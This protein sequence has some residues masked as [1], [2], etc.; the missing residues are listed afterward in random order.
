MSPS[1]RLSNEELVQT[2]LRSDPAAYRVAQE[3]Q[4]AHFRDLYQGAS[5]ALRDELGLAVENHGDSVLFAASGVPHL[6]F[7]R[8][9]RLGAGGSVSLEEVDSALASFARRGVERFIV[10]VEPAASNAATRKLLAQRRLV[11]F[12]RPWVK[13]MR[14]P[15]P[16]KAID[17]DFEIAELTRSDADLFARLL[18]DV[19]GFPHAG[20][21]PYAQAV[22][23]AGHRCYL[24]REQG[25]PAAA[26]AM[27]IEGQ[28]AY[29]A[30]AVT[31]PA[32]RRR[33]AQRALMQRRIS[34]AV[35]AGCTQLAIET[36]FPIA[37]EENP[38]YRNMLHMGF[39]A[40]GKRDN[41]TLEG[42]T[43]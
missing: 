5:E 33:S 16:A 43:W 41:Y 1:A 7:N 6:M 25:K 24:A 35:A 29:F 14:G 9:E 12:R 28:A 40:V 13:L 2:A 39:V 30:G 21:K 26:A 32:F 17:S 15:E 31:L 11:P 18:T 20:G 8:L 10:Q 38:S 4:E 27:Y 19:F 42:T 37:R 22:G 34:D 3:V 36:G 23:R